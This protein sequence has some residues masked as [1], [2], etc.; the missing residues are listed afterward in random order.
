[1]RVSDIQPR[2]LLGPG[3]SQVRE[4]I[5]TTMAHDTVGHLDPQFLRIMDEVNEGLRVLFGT[6]NRMTFPVSATGSAGMQAS[7]VNMLEP[8]DT[9]IIGVNGLFGARLAEMARRLG[10]E[11]VTVEADWGRIVPP[12]EILEAHRNHPDARLV[13]LVHAETST[14]VR[15]PLGEVGAALRD[16]GTM[17]VVDAV[18]SLGGIPVDVDDNGID[19]CYSATQKCL[20]VPPGLAPI[21]FSK[22]AMARIESRSTP[23]QSWYLDVSLIAGY[24]GQERRYHHTAPINSVYALHEGLVI[25]EEEGLETCFRRHEEV[26][27]ALQ[28][29]LVERGFSLFA[30]E[31]H[32]LPQLTSVE[33][34]D[35]REEGP[36][37]KALLEEHH[38]E[39][40][41]GLG[42]VNGKLWRIGLMGAGANH[43]SVERLLAAVD[44]LLAAG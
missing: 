2:L 21:T 41:G 32:R 8:G 33:L 20:G 5:L 27:I 35:G 44:V 11:V 42:P 30:Q 25:I 16:S 26:G 38:I 14:G 43:K 36:L 6:S 15:Q 13:A 17:F 23:S 7:L 31:G 28:N 37:R 18:T 4:R 22:K 34:P 12:D 40:G 19:V 39:I 3:P 1:M 9:A 24:L 10:C 29:A